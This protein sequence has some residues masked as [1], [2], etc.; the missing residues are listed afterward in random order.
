M[1]VHLLL[2]VILLSGSCCSL[3]WRLWKSAQNSKSVLFLDAVLIYEVLKVLLV[4]DIECFLLVLL[5]VVSTFSDHLRKLSHPPFHLLLLLSLSEVPQEH[6]L[7]ELWLTIIKLLC[8]P[9]R[10]EFVCKWRVH[11][12]LDLLILVN[13]LDFQTALSSSMATV[14]CSETLGDAVGSAILDHILQIFIALAPLRSGRGNLYRS[15]QVLD[16]VYG[17]FS[18]LGTLRILN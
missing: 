12:L 17:I 18:M 15:V 14:G 11:L 6:W 4:H 10:L 7:R 5:L 9:R 13:H 2:D 3:H 1:L 8:C 16:G